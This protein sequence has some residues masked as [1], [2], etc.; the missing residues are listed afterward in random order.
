VSFILLFGSTGRPEPQSQV[1]RY[2]FAIFLLKKRVNPAKNKDK[3]HP[4]PAKFMNKNKRTILLNILWIAIS[5]IIC[6]AVFL[7]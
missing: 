5:A 1:K 3:F 7:M 4:I 6:V 2:K